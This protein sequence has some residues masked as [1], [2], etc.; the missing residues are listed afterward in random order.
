MNTRKIPIW[1]EAHKNQWLSQGKI[2]ELFSIEGRAFGPWFDMV[3]PRIKSITEQTR[4][5]TGTSKKYLVKHVWAAS[6]AHGV[7]LRPSYAT[8][9]EDVLRLEIDRLNEQLELE[10][11]HIRVKVITVDSAP[12]SIALIRMLAS[13]VEAQPIPGVYFLL[14]RDGDISYVGQ[15]GNVLSRMAGHQDKDFSSVRMIHIKDEKK[16]LEVEA[17]LIKILAPPFNKT[18]LGF[19]REIVGAT[20]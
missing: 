10:R 20:G 18:G 11:K 2:K 4:N 12:E 13:S 7:V 16:R 3:K 19:R 15:S 17:Q 9:P 1:L 8:S 5:N 14:R 6:L